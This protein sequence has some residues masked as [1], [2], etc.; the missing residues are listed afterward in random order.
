MSH[1]RK[2][3]TISITVAV[4]TIRKEEDLSSLVSGASFGIF[5]TIFLLLQVSKTCRFSA[6]RFHR[7]VVQALEFVILNISEYVLHMKPCR[8]VEVTLVPSMAS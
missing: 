1:I 3:D 4:K 8:Y 2:T 5:S 6:T 7:R